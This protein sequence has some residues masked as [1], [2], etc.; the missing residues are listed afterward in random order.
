LGAFS[1][2]REGEG[3]AEGGGGREKEGE[4]GEERGGRRKRSNLILDIRCLPVNHNLERFEY[5]Q[6]EPVPNSAIFPNILCHG[7]KIKEFVI[8]APIGDDEFSDF[9]RA[10]AR[11]KFLR[12]LS[13]FFHFRIF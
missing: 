11:S 6:T 2:K 13:T 7:N 1:G 10:I 9:T 12:N 8:H 5:D 4:G 3:R